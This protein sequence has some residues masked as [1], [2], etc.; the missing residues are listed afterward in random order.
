M[1]CFVVLVKYTDAYHRTGTARLKV[2][3]PD[4]RKARQKAEKELKEIEKFSPRK[5]IRSFDLK[6]IQVVQKAQ[7]LKREGL[8]ISRN[9]IKTGLEVWELRGTIDA[10]TN[11][12]FEDL[13]DEARIE[14]T[15]KIILDCR[16]LEYINSTGIGTIVAAHSEMKLKLANVPQKITEIL[17]VVGLDSLLKLYYSVEEALEDF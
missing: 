2:K 4:S 5:N 17:V 13:L 8:L 14:G 9:N 15:G 1:P 3:A 12:Q 10:S 11:K 16:G 7:P 6:S